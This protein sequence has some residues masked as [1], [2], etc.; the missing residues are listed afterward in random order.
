M[1]DLINGAE[2]LILQNIR[3]QSTGTSAYFIQDMDG[4]DILDGQN[5]VL[6][7]TNRNNSDDVLLLPVRLHAGFT[8]DVLNQPETPK[9]SES[10][11]YPDFVTKFSGF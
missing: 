2:N 5:I 4:R 10:F 11:F 9:I 6:F 1:F 8:T 3:W 7:A